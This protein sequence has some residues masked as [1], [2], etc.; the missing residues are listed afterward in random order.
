MMS[1]FLIERA[2]FSMILV[3]GF[4][5]QSENNIVGDSGLA[6]RVRHG[7]LT[8]MV[9]VLSRGPAVEW[10]LRGKTMNAMILEKST[11]AVA[12][13]T[14]VEGEIRSKAPG[15]T[16]AE[17]GTD[18]IVPLIQKIIVPSIAEFEKL[19]SEL[20]EARTYLQS[21]GERLQ[22]E[23][24]RYIELSQTA[25]ESVKIISGA[26]GEWRKAGYPVRASTKC[27]SGLPGTF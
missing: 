11:Q 25:T 12:A 21:K 15:E 24:A 8:G 26:V 27:E 10:I 1:W 18:S 19:I 14:E 22:R 17:P 16:G 3:L 4:W 23:A 5:Q 13:T 20:Q 6:C 2:C 9:Q 7:P